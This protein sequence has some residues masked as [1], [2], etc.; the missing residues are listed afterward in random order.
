MKKIIVSICL[1][2]FLFA[3]RSTSLAWS[4]AGHMEIAAIAY[5]D[6]SAANK[7]NVIEILKHHPDC[8]KWKEAYAASL[9]D[10]DFDTFVFMRASTWPDEIRRKG[11]PYDHPLWHFID[12][13]LEPPTFPDKPSPYPT[14]DILFGISQSEKFIKD[15]NS[16]P[17]VRA[18]Y[19]SWLIHLLGDIH[20]PLHCA[21]LVNSNYLAPSGD[22]G[23]NDF[24]VKPA[25]AGVNL[26]S[27]WDK[28]L[29]AT[30]NFRTELNYAIQISADHP[31]SSLTE[32]AKD[33]TPVA[34]SKESRL[35]A[36]ESGYLHGSLQ[37]STQ[38]DDAPA[39]P[40]GYTKNMKTIAER[41][42]ALAG[43][44]L[45]DE[46]RNVVKP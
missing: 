29:G 36:I 33:K 18:A 11:N 42:A 38:A 8:Q 28:S 46:I 16:T 41:R 15:T 26:H 39:L 40:V 43:W 10:F 14:N 34:W 23:G 20:Q 27:I 31:R 44:R 22:K 37:G 24:F 19:L 25:D 30:I 45:A 1:L 17:E 13:S 6:L 2:G 4:A 5:R 32:L 21:T 12:Y 7:T 3:S 9:S 35:I